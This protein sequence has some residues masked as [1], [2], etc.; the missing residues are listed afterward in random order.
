MAIT[1]LGLGLGFI[2][3]MFGKATTGLDD[4]INQEDDPPAASA[5]KPIMLSK[6]SKT[7]Q[8]GKEGVLKM[9][10]YN[11]ITAQLDDVQ[12][13]V[14]CGTITLSSTQMDSPLDVPGRES[15]MYTY[16]FGIPAGTAEGTYLCEVNAYKD[17]VSPSPGTLIAEIDRTSFTLIVKS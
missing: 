17:V 1:M 3:G 16:V 7:I 13:K 10:L 4:M 14:T 6:D 12:P 5:A 2:K 9:R 15:K 11:P 8:A